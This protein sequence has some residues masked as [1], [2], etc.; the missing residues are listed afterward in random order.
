MS[1]NMRNFDPNKQQLPNN[2]R[3]RRAWEAEQTRRKRLAAKYGN[4]PVKSAKELAGT[5]ADALKKAP[6]LPHPV[7]SPGRVR[8]IK[9]SGASSTR[10]ATCTPSDEPRASSTPVNED[11]RDE[12]GALRA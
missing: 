4:A 12:H 7:V 9:A 5:I 3:V 1:L 6:P 2:R 11:N 10:P 8:I